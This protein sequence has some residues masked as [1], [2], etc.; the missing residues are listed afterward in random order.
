MPAKPLNLHPQFKKK[1]LS[2]FIR[3]GCKR[4][5]RLSLYSHD[6][7]IALGMAPDQEARSVMGQIGEMGKE[8]QDEKI[9][10]L[11]LIFNQENIVA[12]PS[13]PESR[14]VAHSLEDKLSELRPY[15]FVVEAE[16]D[17]NTPTFR[18]G[19]N[20]TEL[21][22][23][24]GRKLGLGVNQA[25]LIQVFPARCDSPADE[26]LAFCTE[27]H[28]SGELTP[29]AADDTRLR[30]RVIDIKMASEPGA[31]YFAE[32][33][34]YGLTLA[35]WLHDGGHN[36][37][38]VVIAASAVW[39]GSYVDSS[40]TQ[41]RKKILASGE[42]PTLETLATA[43]EKDLEIAHFETFVSKI[44][45]FF[46]DTLPT[47][48][49]TPLANLVPFVNYSCQGCEFM[50]YP[51]EK[52]GIKS[53]HELWCWPLSK[54]NE[55]LSMVFG[56]SRGNALQLKVNTLSELA[57][58]PPD[59]P[60]FRENAILR[61]QSTRF[62]GRAKALLGNLTASLADA[63]SDSLMPQ[64]PDL[65]VYLFLDY[66]I[67]S[68]VTITFGIR[69][70]WLEPLPFD[71]TIPAA[72]RRSESWDT[73]SGQDEVYV[74]ESRDLEREEQEFLKFLKTLRKILNRV[75]S[76]DNTAI[77]EGRRVEGTRQK[78]S[79]YQIY[80]WDEA[81]RRHLQRLVGRHL[82]AIIRD[83]SIRDMAW[84]FPSA[85]L[86]P[87]ADQATS[88]SPFTL[89]SRVVQNTVAVPLPHHYTL[90]G[91]AQH[92]HGPDYTPPVI[93]PL[94]HDP[95][96]DLIPGERIH[97]LWGKKASR[98]TEK[99]ETILRTTRF[100]LAAMQV[101]AER[102]KDD[103]GDALLP[104]RLAAPTLGTL[105]T[106]VLSSEP[107]FSQ[108]LFEHARLNVAINDLDG[109]TVRAMP[110]H[111]REARFRSA[112]LTRRLV[113]QEHDHALQRLQEFTPR[114]LGTI[115]GLMIY[116]LN[117][118]SRE[119]NARAGDIG[120]ALS[121]INQ[122][123]FLL[124]HPYSVLNP[125]FKIVGPGARE[126][127][128]TIAGAGLT[129]VS[130]EAIDR[131]NGTIALKPDTTSHIVAS[132]D[133]HATEL[134]LE[135][136]RLLDLSAN[137]ILDKFEF[138]G[139]TSKVKYTLKGIGYPAIAYHNPAMRRALGIPET[140]PINPPDPTPAARFLWDGPALKG[141][142]LPRQLAAVRTDLKP[143]LQHLQRPL[144]TSQWDAWEWG[145]THRL[146][147]IWGPPGTGKSQTLRALLVGAL[148]DA[149]KRGITLRILVSSN[150][151]AATDNVLEGLPELL[152]HALPAVP[153]D[154]FRLESE[155]K[156][157]PSNLDAS[158][159][160]IKV[161]TR[162]STPEV[163]AIQRRLDVPQGL[164]VVGS[165]PHQ[166]HN[167]GI[168]YHTPSGLTGARRNQA[169]QRHWFDL[170]IIDEAS[171][172][173][174]ASATLVVSKA[175]EDGAYV[176]AR[177]PKLPRDWSTS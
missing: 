30:L 112:I 175:A 90:F 173:D 137:V 151:Y 52:D 176:L 169:T 73:F 45:R 19:M 5:L 70:Y 36:K 159:V 64:W 130:I 153:V 150:T 125:H 95:L 86:L 25:D 131:V 55:H 32:V 136:A 82:N 88:K 167:L 143:I 97:E 23:E 43:L 104:T 163:Q 96:S 60:V 53:H 111:E 140:Q 49:N 121:P 74:V 33:V 17:S 115:P 83:A 93:H 78:R 94:Y 158:I 76:L 57:A 129:A 155:S 116:E 144:N 165:T 135:D 87:Q 170:I 62:P 68:A 85:E 84:L 35:A 56:L 38:F 117:Q 126:E 157:R 164:V 10:E 50:G 18:Q 142:T 14:A 16:Y 79:T 7:R 101:I 145:L 41:T 118:F 71:S 58:L 22:D 39:P 34:Y 160:S 177:L 162:P 89:L 114:E 15:Q 27:V 46:N 13:W 106:R 9:K 29:I 37:K 100:K 66:D 21:V 63:G 102:L 59:A 67:A 4:R 3:N 31:N 133:P 174:V 154:I 98:L 138:D 42:T 72:D 8:W 61:T 152:A 128:Q 69:A 109:Y 81:Q 11:G 103:L 119:L 77:Q 146:S 113:G 141:A 108:L 51:W 91:V 132:A 20:L 122:P 127:V 147:L 48:L 110:P 148:L 92:Y 28:P 44:R 40:L 123:H 24:H 1:V 47:V 161:Q 65:K 107:P 172:M 168:A 156:D 12:S 80:L 166:I 2:S 120:Y 149:N 26:S 6:A 139:I 171:Q 54:Q 105:P 134:N 99:Q 75:I 124:K